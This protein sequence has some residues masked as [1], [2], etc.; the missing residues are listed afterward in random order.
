MAGFFSKLFSGK[1]GSVIGIDVGSAAIKVVELYRSKGKAVLKTYGEIALGPYGGQKAGQAV[2]LTT[3]QVCTALKDVLKEADIQSTSAGIAVP[4]KSSMVTVFRL[5]PME[6]KDIPH[7]VP[8]EARKYIPVP[9]GEVA[10]DWS[11][12]PSFEGG[13]E[14]EEA[15]KDVEILL[16][17]IHNMV[18]NGLS[19]IVTE[20]GLSASFYE[21]EMFSTIRAL[22]DPNENRPMMI[23]DMGA[24]ASKVYIV[25]RG[26]IRESHNISRGSQDI[27]LRIAQSMGIDFEYAEK[28]KRSYGHNSVEHDRQIGEI[29]DLALEPIF[30]EAQRV[31]L[32][33]Q[34]RYSHPIGG[35]ILT[36][37]GCGL[38]GIETWA[39][40]YFQAEV[41]VGHPFIK[42]EAPAF[43]ADVL[44]NAGLE[45]APA[46]G[47]ALRKLQES[48]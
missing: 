26:V 31:L 18:L 4:M 38:K 23:F 40:K 9:I 6:K 48:D 2:K 33:F 41:T 25:E 10:L 16:V 21:I 42:V 29:V 43:L 15:K 46:I 14:E 1:E 47:L 28:L 7:V 34:K 45:F 13:S 3:E 32:T 27:S 24:G 37:G 36:G 19:S 17:A 22:I 44:N 30:T 8:T 39:A 11:V 20:S 12:I 5:P 35:V